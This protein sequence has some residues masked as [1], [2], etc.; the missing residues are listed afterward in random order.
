MQF[1]VVNCSNN[2]P[3]ASGVNGTASNTFTMT[4]CS[5]SCFTINSAD[6]DAADVVTMISNN[7]IPGATFT[8]TSGSRPVGT[9]CWAPTQAM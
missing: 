8:T 6:G 5:N 7:A 3:T 4:A 9:F 1:I 2:L